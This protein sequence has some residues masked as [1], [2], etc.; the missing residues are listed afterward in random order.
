MKPIACLLCI[1][2]AAGLGLG[3]QA[4]QAAQPNLVLVVA[5]DHGLDAGCYGNRVVQTPNLDRLAREGTLY[6]RAFCTT[7]SCSASRSVLLSG[8]HNHQNG[9]YGH[10]HSFHHFS[11]FKTVQSLPAILGKQ[12]YRTARIGKFHVAPEEVYSFQKTLPS[13]GG[14][15]NSVAMANQCQEFVADKSKPFFLY[16]C[17]SDPH[18]G[19][20]KIANQPLSPDLFGNRPNYPGVKEVVY[21]PEKV[22]VPSWMPDN[23]ATRAEIAQYYQAI[24]RLDQGLGR[25][26]EVLKETGQY[27]NTVIIYTADNGSA[28]PGSKTTLY[29]PGMRLPLVVRA[30][31]DLKRGRQSQ[32]MISWVD[33]TPTL[34]D[35]AG[36]KEVLAPALVQA[37]PEER[38]N[39]PRPARDV[40]YTFH[41]RS[42]QETLAKDAVPGWDCVFASHTF[43]EITMYY[44]MRVIRTERFKLILNLAHP[45]PFPF[46]F[47]S[48]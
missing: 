25:L 21:D 32:A 37:D 46:R 29:E 48:F 12:G 17:S 8:L 3:A 22:I 6:T 11:S 36:I 20:G 26:V 2:L 7:A 23:G 34:L 38:R 9:Q 39:N 41:G 45:L 14:N 15:R 35:F 24:S 42:F 30:P 40:P 10:Q 28:M 47:R 19:G 27:E 43:H 18:R 16:F 5:D 44:P 31:G 4:A 1:L 13:A 33:I